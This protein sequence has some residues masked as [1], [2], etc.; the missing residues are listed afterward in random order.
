MT[1]PLVFGPQAAEK[2]GI[3][4]PSGPSEHLYPEFGIP[5]MLVRPFTGGLLAPPLMMGGWARPWELAAEYDLDIAWR[6][7]ERTEVIR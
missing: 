1:E 5:G 3:R 4:G 2:V 7:A 6:P